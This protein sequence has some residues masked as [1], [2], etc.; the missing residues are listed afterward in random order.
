[1]ANSD[2]KLLPGE[3]ILKEGKLNHWKGIENVRGMLYL[4]NRRLI[5][6]S[7]SFALQPHDMYLLLEELVEVKKYW[8]MY[9]APNGFYVLKTDGKKEKFQSWKRKGWVE[10][11]GTMIDGL[12]TTA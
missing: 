10:A 7:G 1:M 9:I 12:A 6:I 8:T 11:I 2:F 3:E 5:F 4:T